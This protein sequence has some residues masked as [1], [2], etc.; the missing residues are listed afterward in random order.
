MRMFN[1]RA[2]SKSLFEVFR[3]ISDYENMVEYLVIFWLSANISSYVDSDMLMSKFMNG[4]QRKMEILLL[5]LKT[6]R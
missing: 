1:Q 5:L 6:Y 2:I 3:W 4:K